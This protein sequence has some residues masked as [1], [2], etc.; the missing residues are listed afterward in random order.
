MSRRLRTIVPVSKDLLEPKLAYKE[1]V[2]NRDRDL[3][4]AQKKYYD[5][6]HG[7][8]EQSSLFP[9]Q[10]VWI[11]DNGITG[12]IQQEESHRSY[13]VTTQNKG[14]IRRNRRQL[15][16]LPPQEDAQETRSDEPEVRTFST[17]VEYNGHQQVQY[18]RSGRKSKPPDR[19]GIWM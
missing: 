10:E 5:R 16:P 14:V 6:R 15:N 8:K 9:G 17:S 11:P 13:S 2:N 4:R 1:T 12:R 7:A 3:K 18:S 19:Y